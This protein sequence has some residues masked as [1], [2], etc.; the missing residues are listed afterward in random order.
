MNALLVA[1]YL[2]DPQDVD[3]IWTGMEDRPEFRS[4]YFPK[5]ML[6]A[7]SLLGEIYQSCGIA[8]PDLERAY[9][10]AQGEKLLKRID[11]CAKGTAL[12]INPSK[13]LLDLY[14]SGDFLKPLESIKEAVRAGK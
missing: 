2:N 11:S 5:D 4:P 14:Q 8:I 1:R 3:P 6:V 12:S 7:S 9:F 13:I 10:E